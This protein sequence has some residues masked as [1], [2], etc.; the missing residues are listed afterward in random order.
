MI[1]HDGVLL[2]FST[3]IIYGKNAIFLSADRSK[4]LLTFILNTNMSIQSSL[5]TTLPNHS[6]I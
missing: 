4:F 1:A 3:V 5:Y 2:L 6:H